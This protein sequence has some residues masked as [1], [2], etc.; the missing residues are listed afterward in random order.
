[1]SEPHFYW[2]NCFVCKKTSSTA[3][4]MK[5]CTRCKSVYYCSQ[6]HQKFHWK[7]HKNLCNYLADAGQE[8]QQFSF[9]S[10]MENSE[11]E[12]WKTFRMNAII[13]CEIMSGKPLELSEKEIFLFP[14]ACRVCHG[15]QDK[16]FDCLS[17]YCVSYCS[18]QHEQEDHL[19]HQYSC[20]LL[21]IAMLADV[22]ESCVNIGMPAIP[23]HVDK[24][25]LG[26]APDILEFLPQ[27]L[28]SQSEI[29]KKELDHCFLSCQLSGVLTLLDNLHKYRPALKEKDT[30]VIHVAG[31]SIYEM[32]GL[33]KWE[34]LLHRLPDVKG[35]EFS[36]VGPGLQD[37]DENQ[38]AVPACHTCQSANKCIKYSVSP[39]RYSLFKQTDSY[40]SPDLVLVQNAGF[41]EFKD[42]AGFEGWDEGWA[43]IKDLVP[44][45][46][47][48]LIFTAYTASEAEKDLER[49]LKYCD[50]EVLVSHQNPMR[51]YR[52][53]R[54]WENDQ[55]KDVFYSN[56]FVTVVSSN[57]S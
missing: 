28:I 31:A 11:T 30:L 19:R 14:R 52:P 29:S 41:S 57:A 32:M 55:N 7:K 34:Y 13:T 54:D 56:Q 51:S 4:A 6:E 42:E 46:E 36:F 37:E 53:C 22:Y 48:L 27:P 8:V 24:T 10:G 1:L 15:V 9:F 2:G 45:S 16:M 3:A 38:P 23:S 39:M 49:L 33:I 43:D 35:I 5:R 50:V 40:S 12:R 25:D 44:G 26:T 21:K 17:C 47:S 18:E 20:R